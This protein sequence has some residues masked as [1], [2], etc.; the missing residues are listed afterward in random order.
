MPNDTTNPLAVALRN[1]GSTSTPAAGTAASV[2]RRAENAPR[3][4]GEGTRMISGHFAPETHRQLR[5]MA[6]QEGCTIQSLLEE[7]LRDLFE[8]HK[9]P[10]A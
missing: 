8:K 5:M 1:V 7:A 2:M 9:H 10:A 6:A 3:R 4:R